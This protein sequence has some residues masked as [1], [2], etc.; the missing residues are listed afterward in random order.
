MTLRDYVNLARRRKWIIL[1]SL[2]LVPVAAVVFSLLQTKL[3]EA[4]AEVLLSRQN[5]A[6]ALT[7]TPD[8]TQSL[9]AD[10]EAETQANLAR[11]PDVARRVTSAAAVEMSA[12]DFLDSSS[13]SAKDNADL[14]EFR[15]ENESAQVAQRLATAYARQFALY[16]RELDTRA[17]TNARV[18]LERTIDELEESGDRGSALYR[19]LL[20]SRQQLRTLEALQTSNAF[21]VRD[22]EKVEQVQPRPL[23]NAAIGI[24][25]GLLLG[26]ALAFL[27]EALDTRV[28]TAGD[29][30][31]L[32]QMPNLGRIPEPP[33]RLQREDGL[34][35]LAQPH[36]VYAEP[37]RMLRT[38]LDIVRL[39]RDLKTIMITSSV[40][41]EGKSTTAANLAVALARA[42]QRV[43]LV[44]LDFRRPYLHKFFRVSAAAGVTQVAL[45]R[46]TLESALAPVPLGGAERRRGLASSLRPPAAGNGRTPDDGSLHVLTAGPPPP[47]PGEFVA[48][49]RLAN[50]LQELRERAD[51]VIVDTPPVLRV[52]DA[53]TLSARVDAVVVVARTNIVR[54]PMLQE[55]HRLLSTAPAAKLGFVL[56][57]AGSEEAYGYG[58]GYGP[59]RAEERERQE[60]HA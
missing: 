34:V 9:Q 7:G 58:H 12:E 23:R 29:I 32:L 31:D 42:G 39:D 10:R 33:K 51:L 21:P 45:G 36:G 43:V 6:A 16:R 38:N 59:T 5:L 15:V 37:F 54:R 17:L 30:T 47:D 4:T 60:E 24:V 49:T 55:L 14:L 19:D 2:V 56:T 20:A 3:Y 46:S 53:L 18:E 57:G 22:A 8:T 27:W 52:G 11:V 40:D 13:V 26:V 25:L 1:Q 48:T 35:M 28:R 41:R 44:D 50:I